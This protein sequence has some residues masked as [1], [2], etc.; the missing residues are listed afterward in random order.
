MACMKPK[1]PTSLHLT[2][3]ISFLA[4]NLLK[5]WVFVYTSVPNPRTVPAKNRH[6]V[7][8]CLV[9]KSEF[10]T[11]IKSPSIEL[12]NESVH[13]CVCSCV[14]KCARNEWKTEVD[15]VC[16]FLLLSTSVWILCLFFIVFLSEPGVHWLARLTGSAA[17]G[18]PPV[19]IYSG[20]RIPPM[21]HHAQQ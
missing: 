17:P 14:C 10:Q 9:G 7:N 8:N 16:S 4:T 20:A 13:I 3:E 1:W 15:F 5:L 12:F 11:W 2:H 21:C 18:N 6:S 19:F